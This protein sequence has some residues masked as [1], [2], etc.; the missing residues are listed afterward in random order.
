MENIDGHGAQSTTSVINT[1]LVPI[2]PP[3]S[4]REHT[5]ES[6]RPQPDPD[7]VLLFPR[8]SPKIYKV[9]KL[10]KGLLEEVTPPD[11]IR[12]KWKLQISERLEQHL[13]QTTQRL[14]NLSPTIR[15]EDTITEAELCMAGK[16]HSAASRFWDSSQ[17]DVIALRPT[18][19]ISCGSKK[20]KKKVQ[21]E[22]G[23]LP[24][25]KH[26]LTT[27]G[28]DPPYVSLGASRPC[29]GG[30][31]AD[32]LGQ[33]QIVERVTFAIQVPLAGTTTICG[34]AARFPIH[35]SK[36]AIERYST[37]GG[38]VDVNGKSY[39][40]TTAHGVVSE[41]VHIIA[42]E[43]SASLDQDLSSS[44]P[45]TDTD[46]D[47]DLP[48][49]RKTIILDM[50]KQAAWVE[51]PFP[52]ILAYLQSGTTSGDW[53]FSE[54]AP[55][56][57]D[58]V[59]F[60]IEKFTSTTNGYREE[61]SILMSI[62]DHLPLKDLP[63]GEVNIVTGCGTVPYK[64]TLLDGNNS[65]IIKGTAMLTKKIRIAF[66]PYFGLSGSWVVYHGQLCGVVYA[67]YSQDPYLHM[68][69]AETVFQDIKDMLATSRVR[70]TSREETQNQQSPRFDTM[71]ESL[72]ST[73]MTSTSGGSTSNLLT[74]ENPFL[75]NNI[76]NQMEASHYDS[77]QPYPLVP[78]PKAC[79]PMNFVPRSL[80]ADTSYLPGPLVKTNQPA[81]MTS[82]SEL[83][84]RVIQRFGTQ[85][86]PLVA[87]LIPL[88]RDKHSVLLTQ[89]RE[90]GWTLP[91]GGWQTDEATA[92]DAAKRVAWEE[93]GV[94]CSIER[95]LGWSPKRQGSGKLPSPAFRA[96]YY[97]FE[98]VLEKQE[99]QW[100]G[101]QQSRQWFTYSQA[102]E[103]L[104]DQPEMLDALDQCTIFHDTYMGI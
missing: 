101:R 37:V 13:L 43:N 62:R 61:T 32:P 80:Q 96:S 51:I 91:Y 71:V 97:F 27:Y 83:T 17:E 81:P 1:K 69:P 36:G 21:E 66:A 19:W 52:Q 38:L 23:R 70:V 39:G 31:S 64:G 53:R 59:L 34:A 98:G 50:Q 45:D 20:C 73:N 86:E 58:F 67:A 102:R 22:I 26:F 15:A 42:S 35:T 54:K 48:P 72:I 78:V 2:C 33:G 100:P 63:V 6:V 60:D 3:A 25:L 93:E 12:E 28:M 75:Y 103:A 76:P 77:L 44:D 87:G 94:R 47:E 24:Y 14:E 89:S 95:D 7:F 82:I 92:Q 68:I 46:S 74:H 40:L 84:G 5:K 29:A 9:G 16:K 49:G 41:C 57:S 30:N 56:T 55:K 10:Y 90:E 79:L 11:I 88:S 65:V 4:S 104:A 85:G 8:N 18:V 99:D